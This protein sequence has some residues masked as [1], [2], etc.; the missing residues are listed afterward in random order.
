MTARFPR[1]KAHYPEAELPNQRLRQ[2]R[3]SPRQTLRR[4]TS[5]VAGLSPV[6]IR[7]RLGVSGSQFALQLGFIFNS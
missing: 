3:Q 6:R 2:I 4:T 1:T 5:S 7:L